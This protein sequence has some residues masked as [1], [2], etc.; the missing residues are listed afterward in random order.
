M[1]YI[2]GSTTFDMSENSYIYSKSPF[3]MK[4]TID[5]PIQFFSSDSSGGGIL[6]DRAKAESFLKMFIFST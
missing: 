2:N 3:I 5:N 1:I 4:G 6:I